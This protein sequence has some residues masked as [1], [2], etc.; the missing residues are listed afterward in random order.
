MAVDALGAAGGQLL[1]WDTRS[2]LMVKSW[3]DVFS[4]SILVEDL[5]TNT[6]WLLTSVHGPNSS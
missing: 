6:E 3:K 2:M 5:T 4:I 1:L